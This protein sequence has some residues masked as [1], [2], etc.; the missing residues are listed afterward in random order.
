ML[1]K[2]MYTGTSWESKSPDQKTIETAH[3]QVHVEQWEKWWMI[4][5]ITYLLNI[6]SIL[7]PVVL[8]IIGIPWW[9]VILSGIVGTCLPAG[10]SMRAYWE[11]KAF[12]ASFSTANRLCY[13]NG[14]VSYVVDR[15]TNLLT[16]SQYYYAASFIKPIV[17]KAWTRFIGGM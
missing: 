14:K 17:R 6:W 4:Y 7:F 11:Y 2:T 16:G 8:I 9:I 5:P 15:Y 13:N 10:L 3:E 12:C 1:G